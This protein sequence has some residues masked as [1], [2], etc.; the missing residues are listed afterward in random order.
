MK[1]NAFLLRDFLTL[2]WPQLSFVIWD[3]AS[4]RWQ[5]IIACPVSQG[6]SSPGVFGLIPHLPLRPFL[7]ILPFKRTAPFDFVPPNCVSS[8]GPQ[9]LPWQRWTGF[10]LRIRFSQDLRMGG[11]RQWNYWVSNSRGK[12]FPLWRALNRTYW[13]S[14]R[15]CNRRESK[16]VCTVLWW[17]SHLGFDLIFCWRLEVSKPHSLTSQHVNYLIVLFWKQEGGEEEEWFLTISTHT[18]LRSH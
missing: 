16:R 17:V 3:L 13:L 8:E 7:D 15:D 6:D 10:P 1:V 2:R 14:L 5:N 4:W 11:R 9:N 12:R 18:W